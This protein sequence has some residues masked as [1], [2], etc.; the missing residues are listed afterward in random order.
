MQNLNLKT[1]QKCNTKQTGSQDKK[2]WRKLCQ[3]NTC[4][5]L[6]KEIHSLCWYKSDLSIHGNKS[7]VSTTSQE[8]SSFTVV[9][10]K[11]FLSV[12]SKAG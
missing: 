12:K 10:M 5:A 7:S 9:F 3:H 11:S 1:A 4:K 8:M 6:E 2:V